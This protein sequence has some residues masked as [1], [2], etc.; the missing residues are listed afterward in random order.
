MLA[1]GLAE[2]QIRAS[3]TGD[4]NGSRGQMI[5]VSSNNTAAC[6][7]MVIGFTSISGI[8]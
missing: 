2:L 7:R 3:V 4:P 5:A 8:R 6:L 1:G